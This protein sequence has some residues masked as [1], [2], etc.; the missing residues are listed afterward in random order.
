MWTRSHV[1]IAGSKKTDRMANEAAT[2]SS[3]RTINK[4][5][6][7]RFNKRATKNDSRNMANF[8]ELNIFLETTRRWALKDPP[9][10]GHIQV[11]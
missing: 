7:K 5:P 3:T 6:T 4:I 11:I 1:D 9:T 2:S 8:L 10:N